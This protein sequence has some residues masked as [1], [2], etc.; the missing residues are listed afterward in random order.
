MAQSEPDDGYE[1]YGVYEAISV[2]SESERPGDGHLGVDTRSL[3]LMERPGVPDDSY[4]GWKQVDSMHDVEVSELPDGR[5][6]EPADKL[7]YGYKDDRLYA[8]FIKE[9]GKAGSEGVVTVA[10]HGDWD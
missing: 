9:S 2:S 3:A 1:L 7:T 8:V 4:G 5:D 10:Y 6:L